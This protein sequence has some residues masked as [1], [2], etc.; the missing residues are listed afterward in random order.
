GNV[1]ARRG[2]AVSGE[3]DM[4]LFI[5]EARAVTATVWN[6]FEDRR[7]RLRTSLLRQKQTGGQP[8][9]VGHGNPGGLDQI[10]SVAEISGMH[11]CQPNAI[12]ADLPAKFKHRLKL[13]C[14]SFPAV[15]LS[16]ITGHHPR[17]AVTGETE[18]H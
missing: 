15:Y 14:V 2:I 6:I 18:G 7:N 17:A 1:D 10:D 5:A 3:P 12:S 9:A 4:H 8:P 11:G 16:L 13:D